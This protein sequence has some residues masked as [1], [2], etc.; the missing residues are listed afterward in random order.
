VDHEYN[1]RNRG[2][3]EDAVQLGTVH[4]AKGLEW[5]VVF[6]IWAT[7]GMFPSSRT[8]DE[9]GGDAEERRLFYVAVTRARDELVLAVPEIRRTRDGGM[10][11]CKPS[12]FISEL[13]R[14]LVRESFGN[15]M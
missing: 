1:R 9:P 10:F 11:F 13:P 5:P 14:E 2:E 6:V 12:R 3:E 7:E 15:R 8:L 4:Q